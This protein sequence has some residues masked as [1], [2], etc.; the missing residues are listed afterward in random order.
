MEDME[1]R[2]NCLFIWNI[3]QLGSANVD[4]AF[5]YSYSSRAG[6]TE[7]TVYEAWQVRWDWFFLST[8][9]QSMKLAIYSDGSGSIDRDE[10]LQIPQI[11]TNPLAS[12]MIA[13]FDQ[14]YATDLLLDRPWL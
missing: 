10:F 13:I 3:P 12:R 6:A 14:E 2:S 11:A 5:Q 4:A 1:K 7:E 8:R 9:H